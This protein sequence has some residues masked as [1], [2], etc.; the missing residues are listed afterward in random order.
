LEGIEE[1][2]TRMRELVDLAEG[3][4]EVALLL[5]KTLIIFFLPLGV[6]LLNAPYVSRFHRECT[7]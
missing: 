4:S 1:L 7:K 3:K 5:R 2:L 6:S